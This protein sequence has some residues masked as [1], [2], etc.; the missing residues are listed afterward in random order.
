MTVKRRQIAI[1]AYITLSAESILKLHESPRFAGI[2]VFP[3]DALTQDIAKIT[4]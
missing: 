3:S 4:V 1:E 2:A